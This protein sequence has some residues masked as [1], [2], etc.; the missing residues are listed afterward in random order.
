M[1]GASGE[2]QLWPALQTVDPDVVV[3][4]VALDGDGGVILCHRLKRRPDA[5]CVVIYSAFADRTL[6][7]PRC[8]RMPTRCS[9]SEPTPGSSARR[10][11]TSPRLPQ[12]FRFCRSRSA[13]S[14]ARDRAPGRARGPAPRPAPVRGGVDGAAAPLMRTGRRGG[15]GRQPP[16]PRA[17]RVIAARHGG[18]RLRRARALLPRRDSQSD[19]ERRQP[20]GC[21]VT[22][23]H[24]SG[25][26]HRAGCCSRDLMAGTCPA[27]GNRRD[28]CHPSDDSL[29]QRADRGKA[30][31]RAVLRACGAVD[32]VDAAIRR[33][34][35]DSAVVGMA[36]W[37]IRPRGDAPAIGFS[38]TGAVGHSASAGSA[39]R[40][41]PA[42]R[43]GRGATRRIAG[44]RTPCRG[45]KPLIGA[46]CPPES[47]PSSL[48]H[49]GCCA[50]HALEHRPALSSVGGRRPHRQRIG[51]VGDPARRAPVGERHRTR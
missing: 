14:D 8:W 18:R 21:H 50:P 13:G 45:T 41:G 1:V 31:V 30:V 2:R 39:M 25:E 7:S 33:R 44:P 40:V 24:S 9:P 10:C 26:E 11:A 46:Q 3:M 43:R 4:D 12:P 16:S 51:R 17:G 6:I 29:A 20:G 22:G 35:P 36:G 27:G 19:R 28:A 34:P 42:Q 5:P 15:P 32:S 49:D 37:E 47:L 38:R 48:P 23:G